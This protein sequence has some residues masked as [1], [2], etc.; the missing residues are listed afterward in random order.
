MS[1]PT[2]RRG[3]VITNLLEWMH[4][5]QKQKGM[6][7]K[8]IKDFMFHRYRYG[9]REQTLDKNFQQL[10]D[11]GLIYGMRIPPRSNIV[12]YFASPEKHKE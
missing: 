6:T 1:D 2:A 10:I 8:Q 11:H 12:R 3:D 7:K 5:K 9:V 4:K